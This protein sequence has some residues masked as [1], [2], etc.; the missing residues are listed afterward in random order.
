MPRRYQLV[1]AAF[2]MS[3]T[4]MSAGAAD[5][6]GLSWQLLAIDGAIIDATATLEMTSQG[7]ITGQAPCNSFGAQNAAALPALSIG[8]IRATRM[9]CDKLNEEQVFFDA[10]GKMTTARLEGGTNLILSGETG[11]T[12]EFVLDRAD[13]ATVCLTCPPAD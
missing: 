3:L 4:V 2:A 5:I 8:P 1:P 12:M 13:H 9:A 7:A 11:Q 10:L 6:T